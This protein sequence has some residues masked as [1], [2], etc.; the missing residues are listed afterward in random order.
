MKYILKEILKKNLLWKNGLFLNDPS[1]FIDGTAKCRS[2]SLVFIFFT[3]FSWNCTKLFVKTIT[4]HCSSLT[5]Y[6]PFPYFSPNHIDRFH[7]KKILEED[8]KYINVSLFSYDVSISRKKQQQQHKSYWRFNSF[9]HTPVAN[10]LPCC[11][12]N[13][14]SHL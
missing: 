12:R 14:V 6:G 7:G 4:Q 8:F 3:I 1:L 2:E 13:I 5:N 10:R 11:M 9:L